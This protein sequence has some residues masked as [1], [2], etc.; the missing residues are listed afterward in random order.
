MIEAIKYSLYAKPVHSVCITG[1]QSFVRRARAHLSLRRCFQFSDASG[2]HGFSFSSEK[3]PSRSLQLSLKSLSPAL[4]SGFPLKKPFK[5]QG[6]AHNTSLIIGR[7]L[8]SAQDL[9]SH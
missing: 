5:H 8:K 9:R 6:R 3:S 1:D 4:P 7:S 2:V